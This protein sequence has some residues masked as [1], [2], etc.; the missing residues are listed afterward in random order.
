MLVIKDGQGAPTG[1]ATVED[2]GVHTPIHRDADRTALLEALGGLASSAGQGV[3][4][5]VLEAI[6][7]KIIAAPATAAKQDAL[8]ASVDALTAAIRP[9]QNHFAV[10]PGAG[11][12]AQPTRR[13]Y[14]NTAGTL[15]VTA[16]GQNLSYTVTAG[17]LIDIVA[18]HITAAPANTVGQY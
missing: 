12:L 8:K 7:E 9:P 4:V 17:Q 6:V 18:T 3:M 14:C 16:G 1:L 15:T 2:D 5:T 11:A 13:I 10:A